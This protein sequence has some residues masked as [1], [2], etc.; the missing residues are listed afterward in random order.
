MT[1]IGVRNRG[2]TARRSAVGI[3]SRQLQLCLLFEKAIGR[4]T[5]FG[6]ALFCLSFFLILLLLFS[7][8]WP[9][10]LSGPYSK[11]QHWLIWSMEERGDPKF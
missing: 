5:R 8:S 4:S 10:I 9:R 11:I 1:A 3:L 6:W 2:P 7:F